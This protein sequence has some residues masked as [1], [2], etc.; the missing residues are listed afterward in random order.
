MDQKYDPA[1]VERKWRA[2]WEESSLYDFDLDRASDPYYNLMMFPYPSAEGLHVGNVYAFTG[3]DIHGRFQAMRGHD[4]FEPMGFDAFGIHS[5]NFAIKRGIHPKTLIAQNVAHF[6]EQLHRLGGRF[7]WRHAV[8]TTDPEYYRWTQWIFLQLYKGGLA[9]KQKAP[10]NWCPS[11]KTVLANEQVISGRC[12]RCDSEVTQRELEQWFFN[13]T[14][15]A[16]RLLDNLDGL[17]WSEVIK[18]AQRN[19]IGRS[20]GA[21]LHFPLQEHPKESISVFTTRPDTVFGATFLVLAPEHPLVT[22][23]TAEDRRAE[24]EAYVRAALERKSEERTAAGDKSGVFTGGYATNPF[25]GE[26]VPVWVAEYVLWGYGTG[27]IMAVP[28]HDERDFAFATR[29]GLPIVRVVAPAGLEGEDLPELEVAFTEYGTAVHSQEFTGMPSE[30]AKQAVIARAEEIGAGHRRTTYHLRDWLISR[31]RYWGPPIPI[32]YCP[33]CG[34]EPVPEEDLPV[35]LPEVVDFVP[36]GTGE[37]PLASIASFV[38]TTCPRCGGPARRETDVSD[39]FL[40]SAWYFLRYPSSDDNLHAFSPARTQKW[41]PV[42][43]YIGGKEHAVLHL[44]YTRF[45]CMALHDLGFLSF[46]EPFEHFRA[47]GVIT[48]NG[49]KM[50]KSRGNVVNPDEFFDRYGA[51]TLRAYLMFTGP[52][53]E[54]GDFSDH[55]IEGVHRFLHR[56]YHL[57]RENAPGAEATARDEVV[58]RRHRLI[59]RVTEDIESLKYN[60]ALAALME[61]LNFLQREQQVAREDLKTMTLLLAPLAPHIA[62]ELWE[63]LGEAGSVHAAVWPQYDPDLCQEETATIVVQVDGKLRDRVKVPSGSAEEVVRR[64]ALES[65]AVARHVGTG[66]TARYVF[67]PDRLLNIVTR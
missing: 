34:T 40:D 32:V 36:K 19:W 59:R 6:R 2:R 27:A 64:A 30:K 11:C 33:N 41:L 14:R 7:A 55:G 35:L 46:E 25:S 42:E 38:E 66:E 56:L 37:S 48:R 10:V 13:I 50:S 39:N 65:E 47:H 45:I 17:D 23:L 3:A 20:D 21:E 51:D 54:G 5:E 57:V 31:Q 61:Q 12:E 18:T 8:E 67:V 49:A 63:G 22:E 44:L 60:T 1:R 16:D 62:E 29:H 24:V 15:Y 9:H 28:G 58:R 4:V 53:E 26:R 43:M 52:Y